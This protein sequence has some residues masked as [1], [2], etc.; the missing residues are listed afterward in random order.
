[1][2]KVISQNNLPFRN[3]LVASITYYLA[4]EHFGAPGW[5]YGVLYTLVAIASFVYLYSVFT[6]KIVD[7]FDKNSE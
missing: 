5:A 6:D 2:K 7:I 3:P 1:M 4:L